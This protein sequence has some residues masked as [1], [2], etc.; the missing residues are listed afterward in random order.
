MILN[1]DHKYPYAINGDGLPI[2]IDDVNK[3]NRKSTH[4]HCYGCGKELFPVLGE[5]RKHHFRHEKDAACDPDKY[6]HEFAKATIKKRFDEKDT[7]VVKYKA[8]YVCEKYGVCNLAKEYNWRECKHEGVYDLDLK[9]FYDTCE[10]EKGYYQELPDGKKKYI[11]DLMLKDSNDPSKKQT[12]IEVWKTHECTEDKKENGGRII[13]VKI[14]IEEDATKELTESESVRFFNFKRTIKQ[15]PQRTFKHIKLLPGIYEK[16]I[17][18]DESSCSEGLAFDPKAEKEVIISTKEIS[19]DD[20]RLFYYALTKL[21]CFNLCN[22]AAMNRLTRALICK[23]NKQNCPCEEFSYNIQYGE[24]IL[25]LFRD[26]PYW[27]QNS[28]EESR[29]DDLTAKE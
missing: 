27:T 6:L 29:K 19:P 8:E 5:K 9:K 28:E 10:P 24:Q 11:A 4:Y 15:E 17:V 25:K 1:D 26:T 12:C 23:R 3:E 22:Y 14:N 7:F 2:Y 20:T 21:P 18:T 16:V 13:E